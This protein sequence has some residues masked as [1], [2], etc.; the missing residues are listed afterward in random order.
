M[1]AVLQCGGGS[2]VGNHNL[3]LLVAVCR[4]DGVAN[5][6]QRVST[7]RSP[8]NVTQWL[9]QILSS[10]TLDLAYLY[11]RLVREYSGQKITAYPDPPVSREREANVQPHERSNLLEHDDL[12]PIASPDPGQA[13]RVFMSM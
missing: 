10:F 8:R 13:T 11:S 3:E 12:V 7:A 5:G 4:S 2:L 1:E 9:I 6:S